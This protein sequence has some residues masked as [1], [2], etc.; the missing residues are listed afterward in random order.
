MISC[1]AGSTAG[2]RLHPWQLKKP[3]MWS[4]TAG[5]WGLLVK[6]KVVK[7]LEAYGYVLY[8]VTKET[9]WTKERVSNSKWRD[10]KLAII[11]FLLSNN[12]VSLSFFQSPIRD[13]YQVSC[14]RLISS[15]H[16]LNPAAQTTLFTK[17]R[18]LLMHEIPWVKWLMGNNECKVT[19][20]GKLN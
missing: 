3:P 5:L 12:I 14:C 1:I 17:W 9:E 16:V 4:G 8:V 18:I 20:S 15:L 13:D 19:D 6:D 11:F 7:F 10:C 2:C